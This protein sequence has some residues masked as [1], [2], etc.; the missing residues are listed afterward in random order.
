[1]IQSFK[2]LTIKLFSA[3]PLDDFLVLR[4]VWEIIY[5]VSVFNLGALYDVD[6]VNSWILHDF[7][8]EEFF[9]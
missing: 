9:L 1:M 8:Y 4:N 3:I 5:R 7:F 6:I 2:I